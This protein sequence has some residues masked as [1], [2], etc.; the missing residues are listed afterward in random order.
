MDGFFV[1]DKESGV[2]FIV[3][4]KEIQTAAGVIGTLVGAYA[5]YG[6]V[7]VII[8]LLLLSPF[9]TVFAL[10]YLFATVVKNN[11]IFFVGMGVLLILIRFLWG[12]GSQNRAVRI[13]SFVYIFFLSLYLLLDVLHLNIGVYTFFGFFDKFLP[14]GTFAQVVTP[15]E[16]NAK[17][18][19]HWFYRIFLDGCN[20]FFNYSKWAL[21]QILNIDH[22]PYSVALADIN[23]LPVL[24]TVALDIAIG[25]FSL[26]TVLAGAAILIA[27]L[28]VA[29][30]LPYFLA[31]FITITINKGIYTFRSLQACKYMPSSKEH[32]SDPV[33]QAAID[34]EDKTTPTAQTEAAALYLQAAKSGN[35]YAQ[36]LYADCLRRGKGV[37]PNKEEAFVW[38]KKAAS[39][40]ICNAMYMTA[41]NY[42]H[43]YG[44]HKD[45]TL[46]R[47]W[48][49]AALRHQ[50]F[51]AFVQN[52]P[53]LKENADEVMKKSRFTKYM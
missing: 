18:G 28:A 26:I 50:E 8:S 41:L 20:L 52:S 39:H 35:P 30:L 19:N 47:A 9:V 49:M 46:A 32:A 23:I 17:I 27:V 29:I 53:M 3:T 16:I 25:G 31:F 2:G 10:D 37:A 48:L 5:V 7:T 33:L 36:F 6:L 40:G 42:C 12:K 22:T 13:L 34:K 21:S 24:K 4:D 11:L 44:T 45:L 15:A 51:F 1:F 14:D 38:C 43:G